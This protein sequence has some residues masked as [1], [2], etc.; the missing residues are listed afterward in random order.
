MDVISEAGYEPQDQRENEPF[1]ESMQKMNTDLI[2]EVTC[3][4]HQVETKR[5]KLEKEINEA[6]DWYEKYLNLMAEDQKK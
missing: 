1:R 4:I 2:T 3:I 5:V 6:A